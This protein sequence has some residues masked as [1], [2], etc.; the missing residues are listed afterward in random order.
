MASVH[1]LTLR[2]AGSF[3]PVLELWSALH[4]VPHRDDTDSGD[5][6]FA[7]YLDDVQRRQR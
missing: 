3:A 4:V 1:F 7:H 6:P 2:I 5:D